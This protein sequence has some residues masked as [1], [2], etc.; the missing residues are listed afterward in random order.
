MC[1]QEC[2]GSI[3]PDT[4]HFSYN[5]EMKGKVFSVYLKSIG[6]MLTSLNIAIVR[7]RTLIT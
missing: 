3:F 7:L 5:K 1:H 2:F 4:M 6:I